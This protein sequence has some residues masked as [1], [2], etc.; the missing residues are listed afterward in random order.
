MELIGVTPELDLYDQSWPIW[1]Y[2]EQW[3]P[4]KFVF[5]DE[6]RRGQATDSML[7]GGCIVSGANIHQSLLFSNVWVNEHS[8][9]EGT[10][11]LPNVRIGRDC[12]ITRTIID[13]GC[14]IPDG[15]VVGDDPEADAARFE[16]S[17]GG[18]VLVT[19]DAL[20]QQIR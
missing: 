14:D 19:R 3:P 18:I 1:T 16:V 8:H 9:L 11:A 15:T 6:E 2:Q 20:G 12:R 13:A 4:A 7:A 5:D 17:R 10:L